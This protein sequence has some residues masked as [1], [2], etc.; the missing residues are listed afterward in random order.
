[1]D[2]YGPVERFCEIIYLLDQIFMLFSYE[3]RKKKK[4]P[5]NFTYLGLKCIKA[6]N[7]TSGWVEY[8]LTARWEIADST[9]IA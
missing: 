1:M 8:N 2:I 5:I 9:G 3:N 7:F 4:I 6:S